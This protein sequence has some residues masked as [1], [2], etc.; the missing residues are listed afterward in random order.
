MLIGL[1]ISDVTMSLCV[2][3]YDYDTII[4]KNRDYRF[5]FDFFQSR[6]L[7]A[8]TPASVGSI[9]TF[10]ET[11]DFGCKRHGFDFDFFWLA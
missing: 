4:T 1:S 2:I 6:S 7:G 5:D 10:E 11:I 3:R 8:I 9:V